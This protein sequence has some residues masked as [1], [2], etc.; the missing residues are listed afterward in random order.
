VQHLF[1]LLEKVEALEPSDPDFEKKLA[2]FDNEVVT[3]YERCTA[4]G[5]VCVTWKK[6]AC[7]N[8]KEDD[9]L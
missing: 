9:N 3:R 1:D 7:T 6:D 8:S 4:C 5:R 2:K